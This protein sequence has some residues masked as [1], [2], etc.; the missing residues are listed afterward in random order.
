MTNLC[1]TL[2]TAA[3]LMLSCASSA[4]AQLTCDQ[5]LATPLGVSQT[6]TL[7]SFPEFTVNAPCQG[8]QTLHHA[9]YHHFTAPEDGWYAVHVLPSDAT[10][11]VPRIAVLQECGSAY[12][13]IVGYGQSGYP[14]CDQGDS[15]YR[16]YSSVSIRLLAG[17]SR[18]LAIGGA[19]ANDAGSADV[20]V[21]RIGSTLMEGAQ[22]L[23]LGTSSFQ[24][25][26]LEPA[27][28]YA[29]ACDNSSVDRMGNASRFSFIAPKTGSYRFSFCESARYYVALSESPDLPF[30][31]LRT[32]VAG[33]TN[34]GGRLIA[35]LEAGTT[36]YIAAGY[37]QANPDGCNTRTAAVEYIDPCPADYDD[38]GFVDGSDL[39]I[40]LVGWG[41]PRGDIT[42]DG[43][44]NG[45]DLAILIGLWGSCPE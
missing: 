7:L 36:Y 28:P 19:S 2:L 20:Y 1:S 34:T 8:S 32:S 40:L 12:A 16:A 21:V 25:K 5:P 39:T 29:G 44:A 10:P 33:C 41:T 37:P 27:L 18:I 30:A 9:V 35:A 42:G 45:V 38:S 24:V 6:A 15:T 22:Q 3:M 4:R 11:W 43:I 13:D 26:G 14:R 31:T 23:L 17:Q